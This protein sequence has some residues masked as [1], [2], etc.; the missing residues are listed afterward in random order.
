MAR[1]NGGS[2]PLDIPE[3]NWY[4]NPIHQAKYVACT[5]F[6]LRKGP[7]SDTIAT[8]LDLFHMKKYYLHY[9]EQNWG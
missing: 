8:K 1:K 6:D 4:A 7:K 9:I 5:F 3:P 2:P